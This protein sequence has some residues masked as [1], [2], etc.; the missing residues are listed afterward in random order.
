MTKKFEQLIQEERKKTERLNQEEK[1]RT[2]E[3]IG[4]AMLLK[5]YYG[6]SKYESGSEITLNGDQTP[7]CFD[8]N[9][10]DVLSQSTVLSNF[11]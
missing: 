11:V 3:L 4:D 7:F 8:Q 9:D 10:A 6:G 2:D 1:T 5:T